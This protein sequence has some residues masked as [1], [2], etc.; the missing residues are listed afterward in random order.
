MAD[1]RHDTPY[2][3][4]TECH[5]IHT[6]LQDDINGN[7]KTID[8]LVKII[9]GNG[10][11]GLLWKVNALMLRNQWIDKG[12]SIIIGVVASVL[13]SLITLYFTGGI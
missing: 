10:Q 4:P 5:L 11:D 1:G 7:K 9:Y 2:I 6:G 12:T 8:K 3:L 13:G